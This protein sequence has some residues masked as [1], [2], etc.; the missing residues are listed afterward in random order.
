MLLIKNGNTPLHVAASQQKDATFDIVNT[1]LTHGAPT[2]KKNNRN[3]TPLD[4]AVE[5]NNKLII[6][7][8]LDWHSR[9]IELSIGL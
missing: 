4:V 3:Q 2:T 1:L 5:Y 8:L 6:D 9:A 7:V